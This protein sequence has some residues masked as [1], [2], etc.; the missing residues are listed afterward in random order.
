MPTNYVIATVRNQETALDL[1]RLAE[2]HIGSISIITMDVSNLESI[3]S[4]AREVEQLLEVKDG[5]DCLIA[6]AGVLAGGWACAVEGSALP[7]RFDS[8]GRSDRARITNVLSDLID[9]SLTYTRIF[10]QTSLELSVL[11]KNCL[12]FC[13]KEPASRSLSFRPSRDRLGVAFRIRDS[14]PL[15]SNITNF[16]LITGRQSSLNDD[17]FRVE[18]C[19]QYVG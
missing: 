12:P 4:G 11:P 3:R 16:D 7:L 2:K 13:A 17:R 1:H 14:Q 6:N 8:Q 15:V 9:P 19:C 10:K 5:L 18:S